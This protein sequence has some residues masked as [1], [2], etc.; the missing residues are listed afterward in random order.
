MA[1]AYG[2]QKLAEAISKSS[3]RAYRICEIV[4]DGLGM[5]HDIEMESNIARICGIRN[6]IVHGRRREYHLS[7][8]IEDLK[9][10]RKYALL[11]DQHI[12]DYFLLI[13]A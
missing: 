3:F 4:F 9:L 8:S 7:K 2:F 13:E 5:P 6:D 1:S 12:I 11:I 10:M